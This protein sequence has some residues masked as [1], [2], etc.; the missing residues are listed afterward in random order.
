MTKGLK[1]SKLRIEIQI[2]NNENESF[3]DE[4]LFSGE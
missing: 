3:A 1:L 2:R 4:G